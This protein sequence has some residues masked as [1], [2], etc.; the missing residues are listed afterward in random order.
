MVTGKWKKGVKKLTNNDTSKKYTS[1]KYTFTYAQKDDKGVIVQLISCLA[2]GNTVKEAKRNA[3][4][5]I[6]KVE[7][8]ELATDKNVKRAVQKN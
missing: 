7:G 1:K 6:R 4:E 3:I 5:Q 2:S 8:G